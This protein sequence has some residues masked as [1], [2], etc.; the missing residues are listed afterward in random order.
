MKYTSSQL[1]HFVGRALKTNDERYE[2]LSAIIRGGKLRVN[3][4]HEDNARIVTTFN[5]SGE[6]LG[7]PYEKIDCICFCDI[8]NES[9]G[10]HTNK[11]SKFG[12]GF[13]R[14]F[15]VKLGAQPVMYIPINERV[16]KRI[17]G[18]VANSESYYALLA[19]DTTIFGMFLTM[20][21]Q[22]LE[23]KGL[24]L[25]NLFNIPNDK[26]VEVLR[27][28]SDGNIKKLLFNQTAALGEL[29][30]FTK[31]FD[32]MLADD[33]ENNYYMEREWRILSDVNFNLNDIKTIYLPNE[34]YKARFIDEFSSFEGNIQILN[35]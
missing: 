35:D 13:S 16:K 6:R 15:L 29:I 12:I 27:E 1:S 31:I 18:D 25:H 32:P 20:Y 11:Y 17:T 7:E 23:S 19:N 24:F 22:S 26:G 2:L 5:Y 9:L 33:D 4:T 8:P 10:I 14:E 34:E 28:L 30:T 3:L 21:I